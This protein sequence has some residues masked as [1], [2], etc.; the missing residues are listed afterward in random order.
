MCHAASTFQRRARKLRH[1]A[2]DVNKGMKIASAAR[3]YFLGRV[4]HNVGRGIGWSDVNGQ[5]DS[6][7]GE[8]LYDL[9]DDG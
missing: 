1:G 7:L 2:N 5:R 4:E 8:F 9:V 3:L 6:R